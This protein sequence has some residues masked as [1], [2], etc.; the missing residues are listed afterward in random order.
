M[1]YAQIIRKKINKKSDRPK[2]LL[3]DLLKS[4]SS[5]LKKSDLGFIKKAYEYGASA[6]EN[7]TR[8][9][10]E[11]YICHPLSVALILSKMRMDK[12][13]ISAKEMFVS[14]TTSCRSA[15]DIVCLSILI[16]ERISATDKGWQM[17][18]SPLIR[19]WFSWADAPYS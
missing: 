17:Y 5:Y 10:G 8:M 9:S 4:V 2:I 12:Q 11:P 16:L 13:T 3:E 1:D 18:G 6:H 7:Q 14:S 19:A 15:A